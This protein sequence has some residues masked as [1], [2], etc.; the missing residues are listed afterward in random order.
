MKNAKKNR[1]PITWK[2]VHAL[3][4]WEF[5]HLKNC[6][7]EEEKQRTQPEFEVIEA[8]YF[9][10][11]C[12]GFYMSVEDFKEKAREKDEYGTDLMDIIIDNIINDYG[13]LSITKEK[14]TKESFHNASLWGKENPYQKELDKL[15]ESEYDDDLED[16]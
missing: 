12:E 14:Y 9:D 8:I 1:K 4:E 2:D 10:D 6:V 16:E 3:S 7:K 11:G 5:D 15:E 13:H